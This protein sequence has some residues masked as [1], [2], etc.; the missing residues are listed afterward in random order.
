MIPEWFMIPRDGSLMSHIVCMCVCMSY[1]TIH[2]S[3]GWFIDASHG[4]VWFIV[5]LT[6]LYDSIRSIQVAQIVTQIVTQIVIQ[7]IAKQ[8]RSHFGAILGADGGGPWGRLRAHRFHIVSS[9]FT[10]SASYPAHSF[11]L[12]FFIQTK[13]FKKCH[14][15]VKCWWCGKTSLPRYV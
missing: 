2:D 6:T 11:C 3:K 7:I 1:C 5:R 10:F 9:C 12:T 15:L 8:L 4:V 13:K 14:C